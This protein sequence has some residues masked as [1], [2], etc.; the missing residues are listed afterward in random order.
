MENVESA[1]K[2]A[3]Q[4]ASDVR[5]SARRLDDVMKK[6]Q[7]TLERLEALNERSLREFLQVEGV[8]VNLIP[9]SRVE[10]RIRKLKNDP[11]PLPVPAPAP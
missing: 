8:R 5:A 9:D 6:M 3:R 1:S 7:G 2:D 4:A 11:S 10:S